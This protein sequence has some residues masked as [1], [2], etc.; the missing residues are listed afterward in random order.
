MCASRMM[1]SA[2]GCESVAA[3]AAVAAPS[4][5]INTAK[6]QDI[7]H[8]VFYLRPIKIAADSILLIEVQ[9]A[10]HTRDLA[11]GGRG[12]GL[13]PRHQPI[14]IEAKGVQL[15]MARRAARPRRAHAVAD[16]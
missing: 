14:G 3:G 10:G 4:A 16:L 5:A 1:R 6:L 13:Q 12:I 15:V 9:L 11:G 8:A 7:R 2:A